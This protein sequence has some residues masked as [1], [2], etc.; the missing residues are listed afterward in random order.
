M[1]KLKLL[2]ALFML[3]NVVFAGGLLTNYNQSAQYVRMMS[4]N[5][6]LEID[7]VFYNPAGLVKLE[8]GWHFAFNNQTIFQDKTI[9]SDFPLLNDGYY[10]GTTEVPVFPSF[11]GV[12]KKE[13]WA[14]SIGVGP[15]SG[16]G[17]AEF[18]RGLPAFEIP[19]SQ[20]K[21]LLSELGVTGYDVDIYFKGSSVYWGIQL[22]ATYEINEK[23]SVYGGVR[24]LPAKNVYQGHIKD[25]Q[26]QIGGSNYLPASTFLAGASANLQVLADMP[27]ALNPYLEAGG[28]YTL[29]QLQGAGQITAEQ[30]GGIEA[31][32]GLMGLPQEQINAMTL[33]QINGAYVLAS[34]T[35]QDQ[36]NQLSAN[37][38]KMG[39]RIV[40]TEQTG[41]SF[42]PVLGINYSPNDDWNFAFKWEM[43]TFLTLDN[44]PNSDNNYDLWGSK[45]NSDVPGIITAGVG[46]RGLDWLE[47]QLSYNMY[48]DKRVGWGTNTN[49]YAIWGEVDKTKIRQREIDNNYYELGL[50]LQFNLSEKFAVSVGGLRSKKGVADSWQSDLSYSNSS[51]TLGG[52]IMWK[53][54]DKLTL[55][56]GISNTFYQDDE[57]SFDYPPYPDMAGKPITGY[58]NNYGKTTVDLAA[59]LSYSIF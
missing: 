33:N 28:A 41:Q 43:K 48:F 16:G 47:A 37:A 20:T 59:G 1:K 35:F 54:T 40:D 5:A 4:R 29:T 44:K 7:G 55:D 30:K 31:G 36:A 45:V 9:E 49:D 21:T 17:A 22:G 39:D 19:I 11:Y 12:Y 25:I 52:G 53:I 42:I 6:S 51:H 50:G 27:Q 13:K 23:L 56:L 10:K 3:A 2:L 38:G 57:V 58:T 46:Y 24:Y 14:F 34:P 18:T 32:L 8:N 26:L 15:T